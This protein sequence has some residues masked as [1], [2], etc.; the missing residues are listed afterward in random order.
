MNTHIDWLSFSFPVG[1]DSYPE[2]GWHW[3]DIQTALRLYT[4]DGLAE[5][6]ND[7]EVK[8]EGGRAPYAH[9]ASMHNG[10]LVVYWG[11]RLNHGLVQIHGQGMDYVR[12]LGIEKDLLL[13]AAERVTRVDIATDISTN[14]T[15][16]A[17]VE[18]RTSKKQMAH[19][20]V[21]SKSGDTE[22]VGGRT[23]QRF[24]RVYRYCDPH[25]RSHLLRVEHEIKGTLAK[26]VLPE[27]LTLGV[28]DVQASLGKS[29]GWVHP[30][31]KPTN[32]NVQKISAPRNDRTLA[33]TE[34]WMR[35][36]VAAAFKKLVSQGL[37]DNP[38]AWLKEVFLD[39][40]R[41]NSQDD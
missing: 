13:C 23:S 4:Q 39:Q 27:I 33:K 9:G 5:L 32:S 16:V 11:G 26:T 2:Q 21:H 29:F 35:T 7:T 19:A 31:W 25:P 40:L 28:D 6:F 34:L 15:P 10:I 18:Q 8:H 20:F 1:T 14:T 22:Y 12:T 3:E 30:D 38:E 24:A 41:P 37:I 17:F 36:S